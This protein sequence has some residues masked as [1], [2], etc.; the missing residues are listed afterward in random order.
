MTFLTDFD[1]SR[2]VV[3]LVAIGWFGDQSKAFSSHLQAQKRIVMVSCSK[4]IASHIYYI[5]SNRSF[6]GTPSDGPKSEYIG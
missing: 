4:F 6:E 3:G 2:S 1:S 5:I